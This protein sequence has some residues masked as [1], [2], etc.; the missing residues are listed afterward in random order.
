MLRILLVFVTLSWCMVGVAAATV[1]EVPLPELSGRYYDTE[2]YQRTAPFHL[3]PIPVAVHS[4]SL[5]LVGTLTIRLAYCDFD[6]FPTMFAF[7]ANLPDP[8]TEGAWG[9]WFGSDANGSFD[10]SIVFSTRSGASW[11]GLETGFGEVT[12]SG[13]GCPVV[14][15]CW[16]LTLCSEA[17]VEEAYLVVDAEFPIPVGEATWGRIKALF[18]S[19]K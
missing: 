5:R 9:A 4:V 6:P 15:G 10:Q 11:G 17:V 16:P 2:T 18:E 8:A 7:E 14:D 13:M 19:S 3:L 1:V 12:L